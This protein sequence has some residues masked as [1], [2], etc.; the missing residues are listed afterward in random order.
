[1]EQF[2]ERLARLAELSPDELA[3]LESEMVAAFDEADAAADLEAMQS[4][5]DSLDS[6]RAELSGRTPAEA[7]VAEEAPVEE[8]AVAAAENEAPE[9]GEAAPEEAPAEATE[10]EPEAKEEAP[11]EE[12]PAAAPEL[13]VVAEA[14]I[15]E[16]DAPVEAEATTQEGEE[17]VEITAEDVPA[18]NLPVAASAPL[19]TIRA[20]GDIP[21]VTA[22]SVLSDMD[23]VTDAMM[24]K[25][26][27]MRG[28]RGDGEHI[29]V[30]SFRTEDEV[31]DN[32][33]L[34][35]GDT[36]GNARKIRELITDKEA[37]R[38]DALVA[39]AWC[40]PRTPMYE[41][42]TMGSTQR[43][44]RNALPSFSADRG[45]ITWAQ[46]PAL[47]DL[48]G[49]IGLWRHDGSEWESFGEPTGTTETSPANTKPC[50]TIVCGEDQV[51]DVDA[52]TLC[53]NFDNM[54][55]RAFPE[56]IRANTDLT[57]VA[58]SRFA[59]Q[60]LL[61][62]MFA[63]AATGDCGTPAT[64]VGVARDFLFTVQLSA[65]NKRW[66]MRLDP[67]APL[68][69]VAPSWVA[70]AI[71]IDLGLQSPGDNTFT[72][73]R[74]AVNGHLNDINVDPIWYMDDV[75]NTAAF[76]D[77]DTFPAVAHWLLFPTG[78]FLRLDTGDLNI[79]VVRDMDHVQAN[80]YSEFSETFETVAY[81]GPADAA[82][83]V[84]G[85]TAVNLF[86]SSGAPIDLT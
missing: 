31:P 6:I 54:S 5:A 42:P 52:I 65:A 70:D 22:G 74:T 19:V 75:P 41:V 80:T 27:S 86:G 36:N 29:I 15:S 59:E 66:E 39:G 43:P 68:Q 10:P 35:A 20:G 30:A 40:A 51:A 2:Q 82:H 32:R 48:G 83:L 81:M 4:L 67:D 44:I 12:A 18:E 62:K 60:V 84:R 9:V 38:P 78:T 72:T 11:V 21:G 55:T 7:P 1:V 45:G 57:L 13:E 16:S 47:P 64:S 61:T 50:F 33:V 79:G 63:V 49:G 85:V 17:P 3:A 56:W 23:D 34:K 8:A 69:L 76:T 14:E 28:V 46:P 73:S 24:K 71:A 77:C 53:L 25:V 58:Q 26:N 37:L